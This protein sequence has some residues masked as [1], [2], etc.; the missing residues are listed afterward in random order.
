MFVGDD[1]GLAWGA[2]FT[3]LLVYAAYGDVRTRRIPNRLIIAVAL[4]GI[5]FS[6]AFASVGP[7]LLHSVEG[8]GVGLLCWLPFYIAGW[9]GAGDVKLFAAAGLWLGPLRTLEAAV[10]A[11]LVGGV[12][13]VVW[14]VVIYGMRRSASTL[15]LAVSLP[16]I[17]ATTPSPERARR[18]LPYG[19]AL[20]IGA[21]SAGWLPGRWLL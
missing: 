6:V 10:I 13:A 2:V 8:F 19:V 14:M 7:G 9:L 15:S 20:A 12:L 18:T 5:L 17:L 11:A 16:S 4:P 1:W 21:L 3:L